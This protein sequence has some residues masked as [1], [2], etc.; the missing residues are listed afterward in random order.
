[1]KRIL[2]TL[3]VLGILASTAFGSAATLAV[4]GGTIQAGV[5]SS[6]YCDTDGVQ[7]LGW[8]LETDDGKVYFVRL[9]GIST[10]CYGN[11]LFVVVEDGVGNVLASGST[12][13]ASTTF[14]VHFTPP[15]DAA[16]IE[17]LKVWIEGPEGV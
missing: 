2:L 7:V 6:L 17:V 14:V 13:I 11:E 4:E 16:L 5:D 15:V 8:G 12:T 3:V 1:M 9:G 10:D